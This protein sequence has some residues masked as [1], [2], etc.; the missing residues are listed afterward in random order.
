MIARTH[1]KIIISSLK[2]DLEKSGCDLGARASPVVRFT[3]SRSIMERVCVCT[4]VCVYTD[5][6]LYK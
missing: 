2:Q 5:F 4:Y 6:Y 1:G 3:V